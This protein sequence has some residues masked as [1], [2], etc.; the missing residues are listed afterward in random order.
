MVALL[1]SESLSGKFTKLHTV[2]ASKNRNHAPRSLY[3][4][5]PYIW[6]LFFA[7]IP[8]VVEA[9]IH[10]NASKEV[11]TTSPPFHSESHVLCVKAATDTTFTFWWQHH[12]VAIGKP[13]WQVRKSLHWQQATIEITHRGHSI[14]A[15]LRHIYMGVVARAHSVHG[16]P[17]NQ[18]IASRE[19]ATASPSWFVEAPLK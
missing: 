8:F 12:F 6:V 19:V 3:Y 11:A 5:I 16:E 7:H 9:R 15:C 1:R 2:A 10:R 13:E 18:H 14:I 17:C 4:C